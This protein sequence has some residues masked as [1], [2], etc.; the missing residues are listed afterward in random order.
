MNVATKPLT[1]CIRIGW[2]ELTVLYDLSTFQLSHVPAVYAA[3][4]PFS[5]HMKEFA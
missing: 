3:Q 5:K 4:A 2:E 1:V